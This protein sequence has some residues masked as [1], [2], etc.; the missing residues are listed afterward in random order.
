MCDCLTSGRGPLTRVPVMPDPSVVSPLSGG[1]TSARTAGDGVGLR[2]GACVGVG[3]EVGVGDEDEVELPPGTPR[4]GVLAGAGDMT[5]AVPTV[6]VGVGVSV[7]AAVGAAVGVAVGVG[8]GVF[9][10]V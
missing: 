7:G 8:A 3:A 5:T 1:W 4:A 9:V 10:G 6:G 2:D